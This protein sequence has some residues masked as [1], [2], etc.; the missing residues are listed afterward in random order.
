MVNSCGFG[1]RRFY[2]PGGKSHFYD[3]M[4]G[5]YLHAF[6]AELALVGID[7][8]QVLTHCNGIIGTDVKA[9]GATDSGDLA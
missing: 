6:A 8:R 5:T 3:G 7:K 4:G 9:L 1:L 2:L